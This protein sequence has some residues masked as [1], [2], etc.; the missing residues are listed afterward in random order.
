[1]FDIN[2]LFSNFNVTSYSLDNLVKKY[3]LN[4]FQ[5]KGQSLDFTCRS[6]ARIIPGQVLSIVICGSQTHTGATA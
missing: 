1:M 6:T 5:C 2:N 3:L 4:S